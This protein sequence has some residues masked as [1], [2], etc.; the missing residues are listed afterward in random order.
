MGKPLKNLPCS[1]ANTSA[2]PKIEVPILCYRF[3][4]AINQVSLKLAGDKQTV[5]RP[6]FKTPTHQGK[7]DLT[8]IV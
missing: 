6:G 3:I 8:L 7:A 4:W 5:R 1:S 2:V